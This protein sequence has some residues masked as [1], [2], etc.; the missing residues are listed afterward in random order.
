MIEAVRN[1]ALLTRNT[2]SITPLIAFCFIPVYQDRKSSLPK[3]LGKVLAAFFAVEAAMFLVF[4]FFPSQSGTFLNMLLCIIIF[5]YLYQKE[6]DLEPSHLWFVFMT[7]CL[8]GSFTYLCY[9][10]AHIFLYPDAMYDEPHLDTL[11]IQI[12][13]GWFLVLLLFYP[14]KKHLGWLV[15]HF[16]EE[17]VW[18]LVWILPASFTLFALVFVP[19]DN[20]LMYL[21]RF[22]EMYVITV[23]ML[24]VMLFLIYTMFYLA[25]HALVE[26]QNMLQKN[27]YLEI[28]AQ[29]YHKLQAHVQETSRLRHDFRHQLTVLAEML[30]TQSYPEMEQYLKQYISSVSGTPLLYCS[31]SAVNAILNHYTAICQASGISIQL[32]IRLKERC[33]IEDID[34]C[35]LLGNLL[36]NAIDGCRH[37]QE[38]QRHITLTV[39]QSAEH[40]LVL[41]IRN[42]Y[43]GTLLIQKG[44]LLSS[45]H[46]GEGQGLKSVQMIAE[47]Y[48]GVLRLQ[49]EKQMFNVKVLLNL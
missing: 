4:L 35:V 43:E 18:R 3:L 44:K 42:P 24:F 29:Q 48:N 1:A 10:V 22:L 46:E 12:A 11:L 47:K 26:Q 6:V 16:H 17:Q 21:G 19:Y 45:K 15:H 5:F 7:A 34:F 9:H 49:H 2:L 25:A 8:I 14:A 27:A 28:Q 36:E 38:E 40:I 20:S 41:Q 30:K 31:S 33:S 23:P 13:C 39:L 37:L 32:S